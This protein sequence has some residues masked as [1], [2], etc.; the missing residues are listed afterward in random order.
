MGIITT[1]ISELVTFIYKEQAIGGNNSYRKIRMSLFEF[2]QTKVQGLMSDDNYEFLYLFNRP[3]KL[4]LHEIADK[5]L[6]INERINRTVK[7]N[8]YLQYIKHIKNIIQKEIGSHKIEEMR[9]IE[10][11]ILDKIK[12]M[13]ES[14]KISIFPDSV[15]RI[16][17]KKNTIVSKLSLS[18]VIFVKNIGAIIGEI[19]SN[20]FDKILSIIDSCFDERTIIK[21]SDKEKNIAVGYIIFE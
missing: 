15:D 6:V 11:E 16:I 20:D 2:F 1:D 14:G 10:I 19:T 18:N 17:D 13:L 7:I 9:K 12:V 21:K 3:M 4:G 8:E 5:I